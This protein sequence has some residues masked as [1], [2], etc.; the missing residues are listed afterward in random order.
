MPEPVTGAVQT[1]TESETVVAKTRPDSIEELFAGKEV[2]DAA[3]MLE[4]VEAV[5]AMRERGDITEEEFEDAKVEIFA[6][7]PSE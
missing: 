3:E 4:M 2:L 5:H 1:E 6:R 7:L